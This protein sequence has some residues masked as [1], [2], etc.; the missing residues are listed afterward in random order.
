MLPIGDRD[1]AQQMRRPH[2]RRR[3]VDP[4]YGIVGRGASSRLARHRVCSA[5]LQV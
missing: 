3:L 1:I 2:R 4:S 5:M